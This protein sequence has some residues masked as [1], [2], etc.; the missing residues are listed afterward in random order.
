MQ[1]YHNSNLV[2]AGV[3][4]R[5]AGRSQPIQ[6][7]HHF[8][9][10]DLYRTCRGR[11]QSETRHILWQYRLLYGLP[12]FSRNRIDNFTGCYINSNYTTERLTTDYVW[13]WLTGLVMVIL[14]SYLAVML[15]YHWGNNIYQ[16]EHKA[17]ARKLILY[18][19]HIPGSSL[20]LTCC[21]AIPSYTSF[22]SSPTAWRDG[23][24]LPITMS[25]TKASRLQMPFT[26]SL[27]SSICLSSVSRAPEWFSEVL[28]LPE[29]LDLHLWLKMVQNLQLKVIQYLSKS[30]NHRH[31][32]YHG[33]GV[34]PTNC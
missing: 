15:Y 16:A 32:P 25:Q 23:C 18:I 27:V 26:P 13:V 2:G 11:P 12:F 7:D 3:G 1:G 19:P 17:V 21:T 8:I 5:E 20:V 29:L 10:L 24:P 14:Y 31:R 9:D 34:L 28:D 4:W 30:C 33:L 22:V 6:S